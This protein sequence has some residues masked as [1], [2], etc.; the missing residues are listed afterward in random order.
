[1]SD[2]EA[3]DFDPLG[4][5]LVDKRAVLHIKFKIL[6]TPTQHQG[7]NARG[8]GHH[9]VAHRSIKL[10]QVIARATVQSIKSCARQ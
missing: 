6:H 2:V 3:L 9:F 4:G 8:I 7:V 10:V 5:R 1:M